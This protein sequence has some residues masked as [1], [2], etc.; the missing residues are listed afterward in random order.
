[1]PIKFDDEGIFALDADYVRAR[2][3]AVHGIV[4]QGRVALIDSATQYSLPMVQDALQ[5]MGLCDADVDFVIL[6]HVHLDHAGGA[7]AYMAAFPNA[8]LVV[9]PKGL[10][11]MVDPSQL[12]A[13]VTAVYGEE[14]AKALYGAIVPVQADRILSPPDKGRISLAGRMLQIWDTPGHA[15][16]HITIWDETAQV[17]FTGDTFGLSYREL[18]VAGRASI[19]PTTTPSQFE[20]DALRQSVQRIAAYNPKALF[21]THF[22]RVEDVPRLT[23][24]FLRLLDDYVQIAL[25]ATG[26]GKAREAAILRALEQLMLQEAE[27]QGWALSAEGVLAVLGLD[28]ELNAQGLN[29]WRTKQEVL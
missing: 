17:F 5:E 7:G 6:T 27:R 24:D 21:L 19:L 26:A 12:W 13:G 23:A 9:H 3:T 28:L 29:Y 8:K 15:R 11:H 22:S 25:T 2:H 20:P 14:R 10:R 1:M 4:H 16:H 18:D